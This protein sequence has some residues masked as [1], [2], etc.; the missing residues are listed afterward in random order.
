MPVNKALTEAVECTRRPLD[1]KSSNLSTV[2]VTQNTITSL[3]N[4]PVYAITVGLLLTYASLM[5][6]HSSDAHHMSVVRIS[7][8]DM[9]PVDSNL[10]TA[11]SLIGENKKIQANYDFIYT[12]NVR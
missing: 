3:L 2:A 11:P 9:S 8:S 7:Q 4:N 1:F 12:A 6:L 5:P 10:N